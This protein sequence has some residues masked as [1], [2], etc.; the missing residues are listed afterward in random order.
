M[1]RPAFASSSPVS[2]STGVLPDTPKKVFGVLPLETSLS[3][4]L[5]SS[6][7]SV[8]VPIVAT[9][10]YAVHWSLATNT[11]WWLS[12]AL[13]RRDNFTLY[14]LPSPVGTHSPEPTAGVSALVAAVFILILYIPA[15]VEVV[16]SVVLV[17]WKSYTVNV[18]KVDS[19]RSC[20]VA[21]RL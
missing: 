9:S 19:V 21:A 10:S 3:E 14:P 13:A 4:M 11:N 5:F 6:S 8:L 1:A 16:L 18:L 12:P 15:R 7:P 20:M 2:W 17:D